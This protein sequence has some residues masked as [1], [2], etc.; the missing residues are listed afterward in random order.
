MLAKIY[1]IISERVM[2]SETDQLPG[3]VKHIPAGRNDSGNKL[4]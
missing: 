2:G 1:K 4:G 3:Y